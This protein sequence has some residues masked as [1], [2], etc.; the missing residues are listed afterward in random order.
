MP[1][2]PD[3]LTITLSPVPGDPRPVEVR[4]RAAL[5]DL[6][7]RHGLRASWPVP[8]TN[9]MPCSGRVPGDLPATLPVTSLESGELGNL[10]S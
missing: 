1:E 7:R 6:L 5:K 10:A 9:E 3:S 2:H 4:W 8:L